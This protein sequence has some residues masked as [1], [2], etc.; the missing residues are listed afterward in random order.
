[1]YLKRSHVPHVVTL[2]NGKSISRS[3]LPDPKTR[4]WVASRKAIVVQAVLAG[5]ITEKEACEMY[6]L[7]EEELEGWCSAVSQHGEMALK[8][9]SLQKYRQIEA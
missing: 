6:S 2:D 1:M 5:L 8:T 9:T 4:R 7:S 3:E